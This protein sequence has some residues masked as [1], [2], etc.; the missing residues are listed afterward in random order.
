MSLKKGD[1]VIIPSI[2]IQNDPDIWLEPDK[3]N[4]SRWEDI[5]IED[6]KDNKRMKMML[7]MGSGLQPRPKPQERKVMKA[8]YFPFGMGQ[9]TCMG[10]P[11]AV[12]LTMTIVNTIVNE[13]DVQIQDPMGLMTEEPAYRRVQVHTYTFPKKKVVATI[14]KRTL[15]K[16]DL[17]KTRESLAHSL[18][19]VSEFLNFKGDDMDDSDE[20]DKTGVEEE[21]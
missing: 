5:Q 20:L 9:H 8:R 19:R 17:R 13:F 21:D 16:D 2:V 15:S 4:P 6:L 18:H 12:W 10:Q 3:F 7:R 11:Y 14:T 1:C